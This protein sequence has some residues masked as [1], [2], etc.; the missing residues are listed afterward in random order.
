[1]VFL[2]SYLLFND[3]QWSTYGTDDPRVTGYPDSTL[4]NRHQGYEI[5]YLINQLMDIWQFNTIADGQKLERLIR[6]YLPSDVRSQRNVAEW[7]RVNWN[8]FL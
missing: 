2:K 6:K 4:F 5:L 1:M 7:L 3:Y 8:K